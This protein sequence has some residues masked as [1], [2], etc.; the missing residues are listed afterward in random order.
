M[1]PRKQHDIIAAAADARKLKKA[2]LRAHRL[3]TNNPHAKF[4]SFEASDNE[5]RRARQGMRKFRSG[6]R[7]TGANLAKRRK[8]SSAAKPAPKR[9]Y[10]INRH[11]CGRRPENCKCYT[12]GRGLKIAR[13]FKRKSFKPIP[14]RVAKSRIQTWRDTGDMPGYMRQVGWKDDMRYSWLFPIA[15]LWRH[16]SN[17]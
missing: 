3:D 12:E 1:P 13:S 2:R 14:G 4:E 6:K 10:R 11:C 7:P 16:F 5:R 17:E 15:F 9:N 8:Q